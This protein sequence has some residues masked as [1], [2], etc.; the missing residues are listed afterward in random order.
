MD[1]REFYAQIDKADDELN[2][3][4]RSLMHIFKDTDHLNHVFDKLA[5]DAEKIKDKDKRE[6]FETVLSYFP[7]CLYEIS[8]KCYKM[9]AEIDKVR[10]FGL[11]ELVI[12]AEKMAKE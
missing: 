11:S 4:S 5:M 12:E 3:V 6:K 7:Y 8:E 1:A 10:E 9:S 2:E